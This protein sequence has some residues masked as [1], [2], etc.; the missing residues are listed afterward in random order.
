MRD[1]LSSLR[2]SLTALA[3]L[4]LWAWPA[5]GGALRSVTIRGVG[6]DLGE[7]PITAEVPSSVSPGLYLLT[8]KAGGPEIPAFVYPLAGK[9][10]IGLVVSELKASANDSYNARIASSSDSLPAGVELARDGPNTRV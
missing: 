10:F 5:L 2:A 6:Q 1:R 7:T 9:T 4:A 3:C 8:P